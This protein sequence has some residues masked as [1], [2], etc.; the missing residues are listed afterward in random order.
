MGNLLLLV[1]LALKNTPLAVLSAWSYERLNI[2]HQIAGYATVIF[3][4]VHACC[5][6]AYFT[7]DG[8]PEILLE[9]EEI[10]GMIAGIAF[11][12]VAFS[13]AIVRRW[14]YELFY[15]L[16][17]SFWVVS[18]VMTGLHQ[19]K[20]GKKILILTIVSG[21]IWG[22]DRIIRIIRLFLYSTNNSVT[23]T[24]L[25][26]GGTRVSLTKA[27]IGAVS[28]KHCFLWIP[29]LR[30]C[31]T[32][33]FTIASMSPTEF[34]VASY[35]GFTSDLHRYA[36]ENPGASVKASVEGPY[37]TMPDAAE[38]DRVV[39]IGG[40]SGGSFTFGTALNML[41]K[42]KADDNKRIVFIW[43]VRHYCE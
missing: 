18:L 27:P 2:L 26:N 17:V 21:A 25:P 39:L 40:G 10:Y 22:L 43:V 41:G 9:L 5:Y 35:D 33:P 42:L 19:P 15:Y 38:Y 28:G 8:R 3:V 31:E 36:K 16:H 7:M 30:S 23:L 4:I 11:L 24:P 37:G 13:G 12:I 6:S 34:V 1:F 32:H 29:T 20:M 14:W